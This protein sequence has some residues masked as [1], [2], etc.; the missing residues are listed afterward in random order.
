MVLVRPAPQR[1]TAAAP[2]RN[3]RIVGDPVRNDLA[4][5]GRPL[6]VTLEVEVRRFVGRAMFARSAA[7]IGSRRSSTDRQ[8]KEV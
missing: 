3:A 4:A 2:V 6:A 1:S 8:I 7:P 5:V